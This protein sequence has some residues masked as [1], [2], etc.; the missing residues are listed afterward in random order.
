MS[1]PIG[2]YII[3]NRVLS[4]AG[5]K[6][7]ITFNGNNRGVT[8]KTLSDGDTSQQVFFHNIIRLDCIDEIYS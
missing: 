3:Y 4:P 8:V 5:E 6:L 2:T 7:A 1:I